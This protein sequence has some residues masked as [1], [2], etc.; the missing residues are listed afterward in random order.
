MTLVEQGKWWKEK[1][2]PDTCCSFI[3]PML[4]KSWILKAK[5]N[6]KER[7]KD[8][9]KTEVRLILII[10][11]SGQVL[12][13]VKLDEWQPRRPNTATTCYAIDGY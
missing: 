6:G 8:I 12:T 13:S 5:K 11:R 7:E 9:I 10:I 2:N 3:P 4:V 1:R